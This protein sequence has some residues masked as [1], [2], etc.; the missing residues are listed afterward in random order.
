M[1]WVFFRAENIG[2]AWVYLS[3][4]FSK[5]LFTIPYY[6][7]M[8]MPILLILLFVFIEWIGREGQY[9]ISDIGQKWYRPLRWA[10]YSLLIFAIGMFMPSVE[11][12][13]IYFQF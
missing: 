6:S 4:I 7:G 2:H 12:P 10:F 9:A 11:S 8:K 5:S 13:F 3:T 1:A